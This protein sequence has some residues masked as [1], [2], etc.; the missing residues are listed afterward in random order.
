M[1]LD[2]NYYPEGKPTGS[3]DS[4]YANNS[5]LPREEAVSMGYTISNKKGG[6]PYKNGE[7]RTL[8]RQ[9]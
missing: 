3:I 5:S 7:H 9:V 2:P 4:N 8:K 1:I 6:R